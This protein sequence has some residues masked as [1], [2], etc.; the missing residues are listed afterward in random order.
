VES[1]NVDQTFL[2]RLLGYG[3]LMIIGTGGT[4]EFPPNIARVID[5]QSAINAQVSRMR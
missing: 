5:F 4:K 1:I 2:G 3:S